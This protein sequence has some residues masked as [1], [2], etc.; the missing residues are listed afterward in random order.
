MPKFLEVT[1]PAAARSAIS[2]ELSGTAA[3][4]SSDKI[5]YVSNGGN[6]DNDGLA[7]GRPKATIAAALAALGGPGEI[8][9]GAGVYNEGALSIPSHVLIS[10]A[11]PYNTSIVVTT[12]NTTLIS[13]NSTK[14]GIRLKDIRLILNENAT[15]STLVDI[16]N[17]FDHSFHN[18]I[19]KGE[20]TAI[21]T[22]TYRTQ[23]GVKLRDNAGVNKFTDC[24]FINLG[25]GLRVDSIYNK[26]TQCAWLS[27]WKSVV[28]GDT[29]NVADNG[30]GGFFNCTFV[31]NLAEFEGGE[32][33]APV[34]TEAHI[35]I[36]GRSNSWYIEGAWMEGCRYGIRVGNST[37][38]G[39]VGM[40]ITNSTI[41]ATEQC[42]QINSAG[43][44][45]LANL[46]FAFDDEDNQPVD[47]TIEGTYSPDGFAANLVTYMR[48]EIPTSV[49]PTFWTYFPRR[50]EKTQIGTGGIKMFGSGAADASIEL[51]SDDPNVNM[52]FTN[53]GNGVFNFY[54][55]TNNAKIVAAGPGSNAALFLSP[56]GAEAVIVGQNASTPNCIFMQGSASGNGAAYINA[57]GSDTNI[58]LQFYSKNAGVIRANGLP[59]ATR[60]TGTATLD[61]GS[62]TAQSFVDLTVTVTGAVTG[63]AVSL[64]TPTAAITAGIAFTAWVSAADTVTVRAHN[65]TAGALDPASGVFRATV[66]R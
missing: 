6:N 30:G 29:T 61:F 20:H 2:A 13:L 66:I 31:G 25:V 48:F 32:G 5:V 62:V 17:S 19:F 1:N 42:L 57:I 14:N 36:E 37:G 49:F 4:K 8:R 24:Q 10:G 11:G 3:Q 65:Y 16:S 39:P 28:G 59:V 51:D 58:D 40:G 18:V 23:V 22:A 64:G 38:G 52:R 47:L 60:L 41:S 9:V 27:C 45:Y 50:F 21:D 43:R 12:P 55:P 34:N 26:F 54:N 33:R 35:D 63:D 7:V 44:T 53:K 15:N 56:K 46:R